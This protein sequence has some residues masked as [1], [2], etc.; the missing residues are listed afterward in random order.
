MRGSSSAPSG[1]IRQ[2]VAHMAMWRASGAVAT[3]GLLAKITKRINHLPHMA[4][5]LLV[6][7]RQPLGPSA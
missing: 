5:M 3:N 7:A 6:I 1:V 2:S 4:R